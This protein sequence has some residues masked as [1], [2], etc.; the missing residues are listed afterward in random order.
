VSLGKGEVNLDYLELREDTIRSLLRV[1]PGLDITKI[2]LESVSVKVPWTSLKTSPVIV[3]LGRVI[4]EI[5]E[6]E[7][8]RP[9]DPL[10]KFLA[11]KEKSK[12][13]LEKEER[14]RAEKD[15]VP[16]APVE[17]ASKRKLV[18]SLA[19]NIVLDIAQLSVTVRVRGSTGGSPLPALSASIER[20]S[21]TSADASWA[22]ADVKELVA[23]QKGNAMLEIRKILTIDS[24]SAS[25]YFADGSEHRILDLPIEGRV[26]LKRNAK[27]SVISDVD[28]QLRVSGIHMAWPWARW[29]AFMKSVESIVWALDRRLD[30]ALLSPRSAEARE[31]AR[32]VRA[33]TADEDDESTT[34]DDEEGASVVAYASPAVRDID[35]LPVHQEEDP[36][37]AIIRE[38]DNEQEQTEALIGG[39]KGTSSLADSVA[40]QVTA[41]LLEDRLANEPFARVKISAEFG[42]FHLQLF[43]EGHC[44]ANPQG[45]NVM[46]GRVEALLNSEKKPEDAV[47]V[48][49]RLD[50][51][52]GGS[53]VA[54]IMQ[55]S[56]LDLSLADAFF[57]ELNTE[58]HRPILMRDRSREQSADEQSEEE[59]GTE[60][61]GDDEESAAA[62]G[63]SPNEDGRF[64]LTETPSGAAPSGGTAPARAKRYIDEAHS[65]KSL[66]EVRATLA[67]CT[68]DPAKNPFA[69]EVDVKTAPIKVF[70]DAGGIGKLKRLIAESMP[71]LPEKPGESE[72]AKK[73]A[74][75]RKRK[76]AEAKK[77][78]MKQ[79]L[80]DDVDLEVI[81]WSRVVL[82]VHLG[83]ITLRLPPP[84]PK[85][86]TALGLQVVVGGV[87]VENLSTNRSSSLRVKVAVHDLSVTWV[88]YNAAWT[89]EHSRASDRVPFIRPFT[90]TAVVELRDYVK[91]LQG[92]GNPRAPGSLVPDAQRAEISVVI[93]GLFVHLT[94]WTYG[95]LLQAYAGIYNFFMARKKRFPTSFP[96]LDLVLAIAAG[97][98]PFYLRL[99]LKRTRIHVDGP[100]E[101]FEWITLMNDPLDDV[102]AAHFAAIAD[103]TFQRLMTLDVG[104]IEVVVEHRQREAANIRLVLSSLD[105]N[106]T[107]YVIHSNLPHRVRP[108]NSRVGRGT[109]ESTHTIVF[110]YT[111]APASD[112]RKHA[113]LANIRL[114]GMRIELEE[115]RGILDASG[116]GKLFGQ[117]GMVLARDPEFGEAPP[118]DSTFPKNISVNLDFGDTE[119]AV[120]RHDAGDLFGR[121]QIPFALIRLE[122]ADKLIL[123]D[124]SR[125]LEAELA[126]VR[127]DHDRLLKHSQQLIAKLEA[128]LME[129]DQQLIATKMTCAQVQSTALEAR[130]RE[131]ALAKRAATLERER[132]KVRDQ[133]NELFRILEKSKALAAAERASP[134]VRGKGGVSLSVQDMLR[135]LSDREIEL[136]T[137]VTAAREEAR[138]YRAELDAMSL[139]LETQ[140]ETHDSALDRYDR[141]AQRLL[142]K[143]EA[144][145]GEVEGMRELVEARD[146]AERE[147]R[148][149]LR[150]LAEYAAAVEARA[151]FFES[152]LSG[153]R[154]G[155]RGGGG[156]AFGK[157]KKKAKREEA[158]LLEAAPPLPSRPT[159]RSIDR[160]F[161]ASPSS[162]SPS[163]SLSLTH[164]APV[165]SSLSPSL[166]LSSSSSSSAS[167]SR[168]RAEVPSA[169][170]RRD[171]TDSPSPSLSPSPTPNRRA[172][173]TD[174]T[175]PPSPSL[176]LSPSLSPSPPPSPQAVRRK[177]R[178]MSKFLKPSLSKRRSK[179]RERER[180]GGSDSEEVVG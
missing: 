135:R 176:P 104:G 125:K 141:Q 48:E 39:T 102:A 83:T 60:Y 47:M 17:S 61:L 120:V 86:P 93:T 75:K 62:G 161:S 121:T 55:V 42:G 111:Y 56:T 57:G 118:T 107:V 105:L 172:P 2:A 115:H 22:V 24:V 177:G 164:T 68:S 6:P 169:K 92:Y 54:R 162:P 59:G 175:P 20:I 77:A 25:Q 129:R 130:H 157:G 133:N 136:E 148:G 32:R 117:L 95:M 128:D 122:A 152:V 44:D 69:V 159:G 36:L 66:A 67:V 145:S 134:G 96:P 14:R 149:E 150:R 72:A 140:A 91:T 4:V 139:K 38:L 18:D 65:L 160:A 31:A 10:P 28:G 73:E 26:Y 30:T 179:G 109:V 99:K 74:A 156:S 123:S 58:T 114:T 170:S 180:G 35:V 131:H 45:F 87:S 52:L 19:E 155:E 137:K 173:N 126:A 81:A 178:G 11:K 64:L 41:S 112:A 132:A 12:K 116:A 151:S 53:R 27:T 70:L 171:A 43:E 158:A 167:S 80:E 15:K 37:L 174:P 3:S 100:P 33:S 46:V 29:T 63:L 154:E 142:A 71:K 110:D 127:G 90:I 103:G 101:N 138:N 79:R 165:S 98:F 8:L 166:P 1:P 89:N 108:N 163:P 106:S 7:Q 21:V 85:V 78:A 147:A 153:E 23:A 168:A 113:H 88:P 76:E 50:R 146:E 40:D 144:M 82:A 84:R 49:A 13:Q 9:Y 124:H 5:E 16:A 51:T 97:T 34:S 143:H 94:P 119:V